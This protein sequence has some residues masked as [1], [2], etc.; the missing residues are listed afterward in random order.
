MDVWETRVI[1]NAIVTLKAQAWRV[2][3][4]E[5]SGWFGDHVGKAERVIGDFIQ[6]LQ[7]QLIMLGSHNGY[8][9]LQGSAGGGL[10]RKSFALRPKVNPAC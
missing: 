7:G 2:S 9:F 4:A 5:W 6:P 8:S 3:L 1:A 10:F